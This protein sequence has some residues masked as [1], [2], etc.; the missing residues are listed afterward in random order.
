MLGHTDPA[1]DHFVSPPP[2]ILR[3]VVKRQQPTFVLVGPAF[4][5]LCTRESATPVLSA[6]S[7]NP[8]T[9]PSKAGLS[10]GRTHWG[11][12]HPCDLL[13]RAFVCSS[14]ARLLRSSLS[15]AED[16]RPW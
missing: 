10:D 7:G 2:P 11:H 3:P 12:S 6:I 9:R 13:P 14:S 8:Y 15:D 5:D 1:S 4:T 16:K